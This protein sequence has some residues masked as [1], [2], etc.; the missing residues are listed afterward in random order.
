MYLN[1][2]FDKIIT[3]EIIKEG[4]FDYGCGGYRF[5][6]I[7]NEKDINAII[8]LPYFNQEWLIYFDYYDYPNKNSEFSKLIVENIYKDESDL[9]VFFYVDNPTPFFEKMDIDF[10]DGTIFVIKLENKFI[11]PG[12]LWN[13]DGSYN[14]NIYGI[15]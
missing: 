9:D 12:Y 13:R 14:K 7:S 2:Y 6:V 1:I 10:V 3:V 4:S 5:W 8:I 15:Q 11:S